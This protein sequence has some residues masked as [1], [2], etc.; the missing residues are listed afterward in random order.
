M[1]VVNAPTAEPVAHPRLRTRLLA[2]VSNRWLGLLQR[3]ALL[4]GAQRYAERY[5]R[6]VLAAH[7]HQPTPDHPRA[8]R[9]MQTLAYLLAT[10]GGSPAQLEEAQAWLERATQLQPHAPSA[11]FNLA[12]LRQRAS[13]HRDAVTAFRRALALATELDRAWYGLGLS[14]QALGSHAEALEAFQANTR[15]QPHS[16]HGWA[17]CARAQQALGDSAAARQ[18][19]DHLRSF[20][21]RAAAELARELW[22]QAPA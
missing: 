2:R 15:L 11:W 19:V 5:T 1:P 20:E 21:P 4:V 22:P 13:L 9:T 14:L 7:L 18:T 16:P 12:Y 10:H 17:A 8:A 6:A 3:A